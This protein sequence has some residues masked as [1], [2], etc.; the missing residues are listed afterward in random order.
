MITTTTC[1][2]GYVDKK[3]KIFMGGDSAGVGRYDIRIRSDVKVFKKEKMLIGYT[4]SFR[5]GQLLRFKLRI[6]EHK[7]TIS[8]YEYM[9]TSFIDSVRKCLRTNGFTEIKDNQEEIGVFLV[10]YKG[11]IYRIDSDLQV[12]MTYDNYDACGCGESYALG[13]IFTNL[14]S[15]S[16]KEIVKNALE[17]AE[18]F[19]AGVRRPFIIL[20]N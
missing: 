7:K 2:V 10:G 8:D 14:K 3:G 6:P 9:C 4:S 1:I 19:S 15:K 5:M 20:E 11:K 17:C 12:G 18:N 16:G 13:S